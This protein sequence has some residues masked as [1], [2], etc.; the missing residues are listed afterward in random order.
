MSVE[1]TKDGFAGAVRDDRLSADA[2]INLSAYG[3]NCNQ[4]TGWLKGAVSTGTPGDR[5]RTNALGLDYY[6]SY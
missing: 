3:Y 2:Y 1:F 6:N 5:N 4:N